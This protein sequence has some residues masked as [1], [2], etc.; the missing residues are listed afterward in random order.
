VLDSGK[1][2]DSSEELGDGHMR[3]GGKKRRKGD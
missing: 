3:E 2:V 1:M